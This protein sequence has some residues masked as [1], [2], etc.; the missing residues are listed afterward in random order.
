M[1]IFI[2]GIVIIID[3]EGN[4]DNDNNSD[5]II[6]PTPMMIRLTTIMTVSLTTSIPHNDNNNWEIIDQ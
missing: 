5:N 3:T 2:T 4:G 1:I 6:L